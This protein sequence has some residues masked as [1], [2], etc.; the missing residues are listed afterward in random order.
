MNE[1][2]SDEIVV[3]FRNRLWSIWHS[4]VKHSAVIFLEALTNQ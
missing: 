4:S 3:F 2:M 1:V